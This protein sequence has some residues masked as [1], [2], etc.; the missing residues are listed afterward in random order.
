MRHSFSLKVLV[1]SMKKRQRKS[2]DYRAKRIER[3]LYG[4]YFERFASKNERSKWPARWEFDRS[5]P[6]SG[7][8]LTVDRPLFWALYIEVFD[9]NIRQNIIIP[10]DSVD[11]LRQR[12][13]SYLKKKKQNKTKNKKRWK[14]HV[15]KSKNSTRQ[16][17]QSSHV[18]QSNQTRV[19]I[20]TFLFYARSSRVIV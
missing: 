13:Q 14:L 4:K 15:L 6:R 1:Q 16:K 20:H 10:K 5:S 7:Q 9:F 2:N 17:R 11:D 3:Q 19:Y 8:T 18:R 12:P